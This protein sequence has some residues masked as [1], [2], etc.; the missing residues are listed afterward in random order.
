MV[1]EL[2]NMTENDWITDEGLRPED[3]YVRT[4]I[5]PEDESA[6][7]LSL[8]L[9][10][11]LGPDRSFLAAATVD[12]NTGAQRMGQT[13]KALGFDRVSRILADFDLRFCPD[14]IV[15]SLKDE[16]ISDYNL[17]LTGS[18]SAD[19]QNGL[20]AMYLAEFLKWPLTTE[21]LDLRLNSHD[22]IEITSLTDDGLLRQTVVPPMVLAVGNA[23]SA[24]LR[25]PTIKD[26]LKSG[27]EPIELRKLPD[28]TEKSFAT[29]TALYR[30]N[31]KR[32][33]KLVETGTSSKKA[34]LL[35]SV[36]K[37][38]GLSNRRRLKD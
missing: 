17:I 15:K 34:S 5:N 14:L 24:F 1:P 11:A 30:N 27:T 6:L 38:W 25:V 36:I 12:N 23:P 3:R 9:K 4:V 35:F 8:R 31:L 13:L 21:V 2:E 32:E 19:G 33:T 16:I 26:R 37:D 28:Q 22:Q 29:L 18:R 7:E 20:T 10:D